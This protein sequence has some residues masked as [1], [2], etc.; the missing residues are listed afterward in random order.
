MKASKNQFDFTPDRAEVFNIR[1]EDL[2]R[3]LDAVKTAFNTRTGFAERDQAFI[4]A[5]TNALNTSRQLVDFKH[6]LYFDLAAVKVLDSQINHL[7]ERLN[8][9][10][11]FNIQL[12]E[13]LSNMNAIALRKTNDSEIQKTVAQIKASGGYMRYFNIFLQQQDQKLVEQFNKQF[14]KYGLSPYD[15]SE[16]S[17]RDAFS[18]VITNDTSLSAQDKAT[19][20]ALYD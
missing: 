12:K 17:S 5:L 3:E 11:G 14:T 15:P 13:R 6:D 19:I 1:L 18:V 7:R 2:R 10:I 8:N 4:E 9:M 20:L 16:F